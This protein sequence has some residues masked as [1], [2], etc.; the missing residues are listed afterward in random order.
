M[1]VGYRNELK[2][3]IPNPSAPQSKQDNAVLRADDN[4]IPFTAESVVFEYPDNFRSLWSECEHHTLDSAA[5]GSDRDRLIGLAR[6]R[7]HRRRL[8]E[9]EHLVCSKRAWKALRLERSFVDA[10]RMI[11]SKCSWATPIAHLHGYF[12]SRGSYSLHFEHI[13]TPAVAISDSRNQLPVADYVPSERLARMFVRSVPFLTELTKSETAVSFQADADMDR[14]RQFVSN[15]FV[16]LLSTLAG[17]AFARTRSEFVVSTD[18][19]FTDEVSA[20]LQDWFQINPYRFP[21][22][23]D[24]LHGELSE[25]LE[26]HR[27]VNDWGYLVS[28]GKSVRFILTRSFQ[29]E[30]EE[31]ED[32]RVIGRSVPFTE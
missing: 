16:S 15:R 11:R 4:R 10:L 14:L 5:L 17:R 12:Y 20:L 18:G 27:V 2:R 25:H 30:A 22:L 29:A 3:R 1:D 7:T 9:L 23:A 28:G 26:G 21:Q 24:D 8:H 13:R 19:Q 32:V 6:L 31:G